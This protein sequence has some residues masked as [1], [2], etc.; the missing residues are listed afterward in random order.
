MVASAILAA[1]QTISSAKLAGQVCRA[2]KPPDL[3]PLN[4][5]VNKHAAVGP[6]HSQGLTLGLNRGNVALQKAIELGNRCAC[7]QYDELG[8]AAN[9]GLVEPQTRRRRNRAAPNVKSRRLSA[10]SSL[11]RRDQQ[12]NRRRKDAN[13]RKA[14]LGEKL[15]G[16][17]L[18]RHAIL[19]RRE[20]ARLG[21]PALHARETLAGEMPQNLASRPCAEKR[22]PHLCPQNPAP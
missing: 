19:A 21:R 4:R 10:A 2:D 22:V 15:L 20:L 8:A 16:L 7:L 18:V 11:P 3:L 6:R 17:A 14:L 12:V 1:R 9:K 13:T 5:V